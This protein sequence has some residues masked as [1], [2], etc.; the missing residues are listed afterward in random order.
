MSLR[1]SVSNFCLPSI[2]S[3]NTM[4]SSTLSH[5]NSLTRQFWPQRNVLT[6]QS[7]NQISLIAAIFIFFSLTNAASCNNPPATC[8]KG[9]ASSTWT[10]CPAENAC[11]SGRKCLGKRWCVCCKD[12]GEFCVANWWECGVEMEG[13]RWGWKTWMGIIGWAGIRNR[14]CGSGNYGRVCSSI[15]VLL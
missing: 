13:G 12:G 3:T 5:Q 1:K 6:M 15:H 10:Q 11:S 4:P 7:L 9:I 14:F 2:H 8:K